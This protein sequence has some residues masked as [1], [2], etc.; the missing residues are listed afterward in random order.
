M[1]PSALIF[2]STLISLFFR[3][4]VGS[5]LISLYV[6]PSSSSFKA[7][8]LRPDSWS[9]AHSWLGAGLIR[10]SILILMVNLVWP[11]LGQKGCVARTCDLLVLHCE[12]LLRCSLIAK[13]LNIVSKQ[14]TYFLDNSI[15]LPPEPIRA[16]LT[17][18]EWEGTGNITSIVCLVY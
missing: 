15:N 3:L 17:R 6:P 2:L 1:P 13:W 8:H 18:P 14:N 11:Y 9:T 7:E 12:A 16:T 4:F 10:W 5:L